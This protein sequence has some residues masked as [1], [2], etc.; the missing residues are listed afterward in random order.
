MTQLR[1]FVRLIGIVL[2]LVRGVWLV[3]TGFSRLS[4]TQKEEHVQAWARTMLARLAIKLVVNGQPPQAGPVLLVA[5]HISWLDIVVMHAARHCR[6]VSK[7][8]VHH[9]PVIGSL[10]DAAGTLYIERESR[11]DAMRVVHHMV[12]S[13]KAG[14][15]LAVFPEGTTGDGTTVMPFHANLIQAAISADAPVQA[16]A[17]HFADCV[18]GAQSLAPCFTGDDTL[19]QSLWRTLQTPNLEAIVSF[20]APQTA[21]QRDRRTWAA[22]LRTAVLELRA[23]AA[24]ASVP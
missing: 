23:D 13:L 20:G 17:L 8:A 16:V 15:V 3:K 10:A 2:H 21:L 12:E 5:N 9:W 22:D 24:N 11:R 7:A 1:A 19:L 18:T 6:F 4:S 14:D